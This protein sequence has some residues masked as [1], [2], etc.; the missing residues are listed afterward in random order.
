[1][2]ALPRGFA[3]APPALPL[4]VKDRF[5]DRAQSHSERESPLDAG[6]RLNPAVSGELEALRAAVTGAPV[7]ASCPCGVPIADGHRHIGTYAR[8]ELAARGTVAT[9]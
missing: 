2:A 3:S 1:M 7:T 5:R 6:D 9:P 4:S 8:G